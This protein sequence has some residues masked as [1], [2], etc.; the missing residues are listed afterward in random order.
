MKINSMV[1]VYLTYNLKHQFLHKS[2]LRNL[3]NYEIVLLIWEYSL[4]IGLI[5]RKRFLENSLGKSPYS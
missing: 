1:S 4:E 5:H 3:L 2:K